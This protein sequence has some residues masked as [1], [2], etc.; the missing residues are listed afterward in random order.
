MDRVFESQHFIM[1]PEVRGLEERTAEYC[2]I[3]GRPDLQP[4]FYPPRS[5]DVLR[6]CADATLA[7]QMLDCQLRTDLAEG[8]RK[9]LEHLKNQGDAGELLRQMQDANWT[10]EKS[11]EPR[12]RN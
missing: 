9:T 5:G 7:R 3:A 2:G 10:V 4:E 1:G 12:A 6:H 11:G 8:I